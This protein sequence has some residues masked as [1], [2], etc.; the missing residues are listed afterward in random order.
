MQPPKNFTFPYPGLQDTTIPVGFGVQADVSLYSIL[1][2]RLPI[3]TFLAYSVNL[4]EGLSVLLA[5]VYFLM[6]A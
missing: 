5:L 1:S 6:I 2:Y 4:P 3:S